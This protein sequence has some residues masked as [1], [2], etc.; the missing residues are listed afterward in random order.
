L[1]TEG[2]RLDVNLFV[3]AARS[4]TALVVEHDS[5]RREGLKLALER[6]G[7]DVLS[8]ESR[9]AASDLL[10]GAP[11]DVLVVGELGTPG[12]YRVIWLSD[13]GSADVIFE[14]TPEGWE[15]AFSNALPDAAV[16]H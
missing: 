1:H 4:R 9:A 5:E 11:A 14:P 13:E 16:R 8:A 10:D 2:W 15:R 7:Y 12:I 6:R 3:Q